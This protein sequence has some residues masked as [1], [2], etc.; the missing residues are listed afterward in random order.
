MLILD[1]YGSHASVEF[2]WECKQNCVDI[3]VGNIILSLKNTG[4]GNR[5]TEV[6]EMASYA[7]WNRRWQLVEETTVTGNLWSGAH[8]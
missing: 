6:P 4:S 8:K 1:G 2:M 5:W 3:F 7:E